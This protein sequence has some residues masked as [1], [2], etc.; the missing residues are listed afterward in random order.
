MHFTDSSRDVLLK[1]L[2]NSGLILSVV[3]AVCAVSLAG[4]NWRGIQ[5][6]GEFPQVSNPERN[7]FLI[8]VSKEGIVLLQQRV[9]PE[10]KSQ[11]GLWNAQLSE[12]I[13][14]VSLPEPRW[15]EFVDI[16]FLGT[17]NTL[18]IFNPP[19]LRL[20]DVKRNLEIKK[21]VPNAK[22]LQH[23]SLRSP[24][25]QS[26]GPPLAVFAI[27]PHDGSVAAAFNVHGDIRFYIY[28]AELEKEIATW[29]VPRYVQD[30]CWSRAGDKLAV[31]FNGRY[32]GTGPLPADGVEELKQFVGWYP[33]PNS[34]P[35]VWVVN[36]QTGEPSLKLK[37]GN[38][39][40]H[41]SFSPDGQL[42]YVSQDEVNQNRARGVIKVFSG[43]SGNEIRT[44][45]AGPNG[46]HGYF[47]VSPD[48]KMIA[49]NASSD[50]PHPF[51]TEPHYA[52]RIPRVVVIDTETGNLLFE[53]HVDESWGYESFL[54]SP[55]GRRLYVTLPES[56]RV[57]RSRIEIYS[58]DNS[59]K[60][61]AAANQ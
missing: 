11:F 2:P 31:L 19:Y 39:Q 1:R 14:E 56:K 59:E 29:T 61:A 50:V 54:F 4:R 30:I 48:G 3:I 15:N 37:T 36:P 42:I 7:A 24:T 60:Q 26:G 5:K 38:Q 12:M 58:L 23:V 51:W 21:V 16:K 20:F 43:S 6:I 57:R 8:D 10:W 34:G 55:D 18:V 35:D 53:R 52:R 32:D 22:Y 45:T 9:S 41:V 28:D 33:S 13:S 25:N 47:L 44:L 46:L 49:A 40:S 17:K 27:N